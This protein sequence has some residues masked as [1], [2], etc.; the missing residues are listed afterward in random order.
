MPACL[1]PPLNELPISSSSFTSKSMHQFQFVSMRSLS[2]VPFIR[3][4]SFQNAQEL[5]C[6]AMQCGVI[7]FVLHVLPLPIN[8]IQSTPN[9]ILFNQ[10]QIHA[11]VS[12]CKHVVSQCRA[13][14]LFEFFPKCSRVG[15]QCNVESFG[16]FSTFFNFH[17]LD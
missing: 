14:H 9:L 1:V 12:I 3:F 17:R 2:V 10:F 13:L 7:R 5:A 4:N 6:N 16:S 15:M 8:S 11:P